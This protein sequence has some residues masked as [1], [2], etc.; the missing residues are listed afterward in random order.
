MGSGCELLGRIGDDIGG[1]ARQV[2]QDL[3]APIRIRVGGRAGVGRTAV[4][5]VLG[6]AGFPAV[7]E[8]PAVDAPGGGDPELDGDVVV[9][10]LSGP[11]RDPDIAALRRAPRGVTVAVVNK[12]DLQPSWAAAARCAVEC[13]AE[14]GVPTL[15][16]VGID[17][18]PGGRDG[19]DQVIAAVGAAVRA[20]DA[21][22]CRAALTALAAAAA[23]G[24]DRDVLEEYLRSDEAVRLA[25]AAAEALGDGVAD[26]RRR[27][28]ARRRLQL[29]GPVAAR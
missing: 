19:R 23:R 3:S 21:H 10:V 26:R 13:E 15:P 4:A 18:E 2:A 28:L 29:R 7:L 20:A 12:A 8:G 11:A 9:Y 1:A 14:T 5:G 22:R 17:R 24:P 25:A 27:D 6:C 16:M